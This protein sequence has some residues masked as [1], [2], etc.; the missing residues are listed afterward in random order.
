[1]L[2]GVLFG[3]GAA[4]CQ[5]LSYLFSRHF[6]RRFGGPAYLLVLSQLV[7]G[8][9]ALA[10]LP[11]VWPDGGIDVGRSGLR[12]LACA[13]FYFVGQGC[14]FMALRHAD[15]S[16]VSPLLGLKVFLLA[17][18]SA[19]FMGGAFS[20]WQ[21]L[22]VLLC[23]CATLAMNW[24]GGSMARSSVAWVMAACLGYSLS[25]I[26]IR[27]SIDSMPRLSTGQASLLTA[28]LVYLV[29]AAMALAATPFFPR[30]RPRTLLAA[31]PFAAAWFCGMLLLFVC[32]AE[33]DVVYGNIVQST[34]GII[35]IALGAWVAK[36]GFEGLEKR[37][38]RSVVLRRAVAAL[39]MTAAIALFYFGRR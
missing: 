31:T 14:F 15:A 39:L 1:M 24:T 25:D 27:L 22:A 17:G 23:V 13:A 30:P 3:L 37:V 18:I 19:L 16:R 5:S 20:P 32:F 2:T 26:C 29:C 7:M 8:L 28:C 36:L 10:L 12:V 38:S 6:I 21:W 9:F 35:S 4:C 11:L 33:I 34:R